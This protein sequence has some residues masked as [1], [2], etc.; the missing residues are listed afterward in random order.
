MTASLVLGMGINYSALFHQPVEELLPYVAIGLVIW[1]FLSAII[2]ES[3][4]AFVAASGMIKQSA[5]PL[6]LFIVRCIIR[7]FINL[8]HQIIIIVVVLVWFHIFPGLG[9]L[10]ALAGLVLLAVNLG[11]LGLLLAMFCTRFRD[12]PQIVLAILQLLF[13]LSP[14]F[15]KPTAELATNPLVSGN[16]FYFSIQSVREPLLTGHV[17]ASML[18]VLMPMTVIG[19]IVA[20]LVYTQTRRGVVHYL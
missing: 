20:L 11:W 3:G 18:T 13:F 12:M 17:P 9:L 2:S 19:W 1:N 7:N 4:E 14:I 16:P 10:W 15:W 6:P 8:A 5:L